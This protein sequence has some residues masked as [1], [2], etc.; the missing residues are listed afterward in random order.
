MYAL[1]LRDILSII[2]FANKYKFGVDIV[3]DKLEK[4]LKEFLP[5]III[6]GIIYLFVPAILVLS[7]SS[8]VLNQVIY[9]GLF[10]LTALLCSFHYGYKKKN[11][12][13]LSLVAP[14]L[15]IPSMFLYGN[16]RDSALNSI[17]YLVSYFICGYIGLS[18]ADMI[19][20][21]KDKKN[22][23]RRRRTVPT[24]VNTSKAEVETDNFS[25]EEIELP[26]KFEEENNSFE[27][28]TESSDRYTEDDINAIL[29][30]LH[31]RK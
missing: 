24:V 31:S 13:L 23:G 22:A 1:I 14:I 29:A 19:K 9:I 3:D 10:P 6:I 26:F 7:N 4:K 25:V 18:L 5:Y 2:G 17:I 27:V 20:T 28:E 11:D 8:E 21:P 12:F 30:E 16:F 15:Y